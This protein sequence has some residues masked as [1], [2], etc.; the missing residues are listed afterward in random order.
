MEMK[1]MKDM[2]TKRQVDPE[3]THT[4]V[5]KQVKHVLFHCSSVQVKNSLWNLTAWVWISHQLCDLGAS[6]LRS[7]L[8]ALVSLSLKWE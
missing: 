8:Y 3:Q 4:N 7:I 2:G 5:Q 1:L 6:Y